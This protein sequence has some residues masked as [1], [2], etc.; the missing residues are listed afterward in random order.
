MEADDDV[1]AAMGFSSFG[2]TKRKFDQRNSPKA[3]GD[4]S[5]ANST[6]LGVRP[7]TV[8]DEHSTVPSTTSRDTFDSGNTAPQ[9]QPSATAEAKH[10]QPA[11][12][13]L[14]AFLARGQSLPDKLPGTDHNQ[15]APPASSEDPAANYMVSFGGPPI[16]HAEL[17]A[18][19]NGVK[20]ENGD[21]AYFLPS[22]VEDPWANFSEQRK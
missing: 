17:N 19:R 22:F 11:A 3:G 21:M 6:R 8:T 9:P 14:A 5:G 1:A 20:D 18:L 15:P 16:P 7:K 10:K 12:G 13:G 2:G 4:A